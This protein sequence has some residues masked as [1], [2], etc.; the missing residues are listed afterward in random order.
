MKQI[1]VIGAGV[2]GLTAA[3]F[4]SRAGLLVMVLEAHVTPGGAPEPY[5]SLRF[6]PLPNTYWA[7]RSPWAN[8][9]PSGMKICRTIL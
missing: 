2:G 5:A 1:V 6:L 8:G 4:L 9:A 3:A 7:E